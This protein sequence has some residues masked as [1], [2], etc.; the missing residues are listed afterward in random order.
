[1]DKAS[2]VKRY[3]GVYEHSPWVAGEAYDDLQGKVDAERLPGAMA[4]CVE[5]A[6]YERKL[7]LINAHPDLAGRA[8]CGGELT[9]DSGEEQASAGV[10]QCTPEEFERF[11]TLNERYRRKF[12]FPFIMAVRD[13]N[14]H[15]ILA[16]FEERLDNDADRE[17]EQA[18]TEIH[19]IARL[20]LAALAEPPHIDIGT[21]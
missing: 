4:A 10:D 12:G 7:A 15:A 5:R 19:K 13:S 6:D 17:F 11:Q 9:A 21:E 3:G 18:M 14:R 16:A 20:R 1:M 8:A 2:F